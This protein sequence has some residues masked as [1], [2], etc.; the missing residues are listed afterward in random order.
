M[1]IK[2]VL[3][4]LCVGIFMSAIVAN[5]QGGPKVPKVELAASPTTDVA[6]KL[7]AVGDIQGLDAAVIADLHPA[8]FIL[9][10][11]SDKAIVGLAVKWVYTDQTGN[12]GRYIHRSDSFA[13][14]KSVAVVPPHERLL[15]V[16]RA[17]LPESLLFAAHTGPSLGALGRSAEPGLATVSEIS[18]TIDTVIFEDG[19]LVGPNE[20]HYDTEIQSRTIAAEQLA[21]QVR[22]AQARGEDPKPLLQEILKAQTF[23][24]TDFVAQWTLQ[25]AHRLLEAPIFDVQLSDLENPPMP[26]KFF[27]KTNGGKS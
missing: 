12:V 20:S 22:E 16:P 26:P 6:L 27:R 23:S 19:E 11:L 13:M 25:Y 2:S 7:V 3:L 10:N 1:R 24:E 8:M 18:A 21:S 9:S 4:T 15:I 5:A 14:I 17:F